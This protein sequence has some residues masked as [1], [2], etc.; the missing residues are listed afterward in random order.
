M[1][2]PSFLIIG[3]QRSAST[4]LHFSLARHP[5]IFMSR[6]KEINFFLRGED[7]SLPSFVDDETTGHTPL[8]LA[9]YEAVFAEA[10][11]QHRAVGEASPSYLFAAV[12]PRIRAVL[13]DVKLVAI[14][15]NPIDQ[16]ASILS[17]WLGRPPVIEELEA[18]L[19]NDELGPNGAPPLARHGRYVDH[20]APYF[21]L[22]PRESIKIV[23]FEELK[24]EPDALLAD[25]ERFLGVEYVPL[26]RLH[27]N[28]SGPA[29]SRFVERALDAKQV[30]RA[31]L[32]GGVLRGLT[33]ALHRIQSANTRPAAPK[34]PPALR[35][36]MN[37]RFYGGSVR[38]LER[39]TGLDLSVWRH[40][41][42]PPDEAI[43]RRQPA[44]ENARSQTRGAGA[45]L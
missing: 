21:D 23:L 8:T 44:F 10:G 42:V 36:E 6:R 1:T 24:R 34:I 32:P 5:Q 19:R 40:C 14:L 17:V 27:L 39:L 29:R 22:F 18:R 33:G 35:S 12:A 11:P 20:L 13:P 9:D 4:T 7:G 45:A 16:A 2:L 25:V 41:P 43:N 3:A 15:R 28:A 38:E 30:A 26:P 31:L 37:E